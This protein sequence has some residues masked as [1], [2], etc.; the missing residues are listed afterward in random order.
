MSFARA[1]HCPSLY[2]DNQKSKADFFQNKGLG[3]GILRNSNY[4]K[5]V[6]INTIQYNPD[7]VL[8]LYTDGITE[9]NI[10]SG[11][12]FGYH[13]L[14]DLLEKHANESPQK[15]QERMI[16]AVYQFRGDRFLNDDYTMV[17]VK[18]K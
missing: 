8:V 5:H 13:R 18:F 1:G 9:A 7:D 2:Y 6:Q 4:E 17:I 10:A 12:E 16:E 15:I 14:R 3:L 11:E